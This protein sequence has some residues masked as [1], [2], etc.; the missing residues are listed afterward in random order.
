MHFTC[1]VVNMRPSICLQM[2]YSVL[3]NVLNCPE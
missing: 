3:P 1:F 2:A